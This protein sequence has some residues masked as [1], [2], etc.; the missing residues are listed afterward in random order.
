MT[1]RVIRELRLEQSCCLVELRLIH[2]SDR[3]TV[4]MLAAIFDDITQIDG[5]M[6]VDVSMETQFDTCNSSMLL[7]PVK[8]SPVC[9]L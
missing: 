1:F 7:S 4:K 5:V 9:K 2:L 8:Q 3:T 6:V